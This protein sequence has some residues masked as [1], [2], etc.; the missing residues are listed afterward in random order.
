LDQLAADPARIPDLP[1]E[2]APL[3][4]DP[5]DDDGGPLLSDDP[6][7]KD[8]SDALMEACRPVRPWPKREPEPVRQPIL[9]RDPVL[10]REP[11]LAREPVKVEL[12]PVL[13]KAPRDGRSI[14][15]D[16]GRGTA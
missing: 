14:G 3:E 15:T 13:A 11:V 1:P 7:E 16:S 12:E 2:V 9:A 6:A 8:G 5:G 4:P 10:V